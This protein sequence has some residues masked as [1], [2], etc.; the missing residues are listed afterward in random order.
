[1]SR[2]ALEAFK[3]SFELSPII[4][5]G[6]VAG[7]IPGGMLP[8][9]ALSDALSFATGLLSGGTVTGDTAFAHYQVM[10]G[11]T[12]IDYKI[13]MYPFANQNVA[14]NAVIKEPLQVDVLMICPANDSNGYLTKLPV[15]MAM[16]ASFDQHNQSGGTYTVATPA[17]L[18][19]DL[20]MTGMK[21]ISHSES[22]QVQSAY[23][24]SFI[25]PLITLADAQQAQN[26]MMSAISAGV[27]ST[28][29]TSGIGQ[30]V[31]SPPSLATPSIAPVAANSAGTGLAGN[32]G[33]GH[34]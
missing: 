23:Q 1:M 14:A 26:S 29:A 22:H 11:S 7:N 19:T 10:P 25:K 12:L 34:N 17:F 33:V 31:G 28:G 9:L 32:S 4:M 27:P 2:A 30:T 24:L 5:T 20:V 18:Y 21:D 3:L 15:I 6:G 13:G 8:I 16:Q